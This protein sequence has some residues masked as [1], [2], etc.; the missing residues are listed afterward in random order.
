MTPGYSYLVQNYSDIG[1]KLI[2]NT[3][4]LGLEKTLDRQWSVGGEYDLQVSKP[5]VGSSATNNIFSLALRY[6]Y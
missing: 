3:A 2:T 5:D 6:A 1:S 4:S